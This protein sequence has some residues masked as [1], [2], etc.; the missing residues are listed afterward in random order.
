MGNVFD[1]LIS[2]E[3][4]IPKENMEYVYILDMIW[5]PDVFGS[6]KIVPGKIVTNVVILENHSFEFILKETGEKY[7][8]NYGWSLMENTPE[9]HEALKLLN[10]EKQKLEAF[11]KEVNLLRKKIKT[12]E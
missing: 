12:L 5:K 10:I 1:A 6:I 8:T 7:C 4:K 9:N 2:K 3:N 11:K